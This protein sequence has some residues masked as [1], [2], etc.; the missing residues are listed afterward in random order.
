[1]DTQEDVE[2]RAMAVFFYSAR[3]GRDENEEGREKKCRNMKTSL[4]YL[5]TSAYVGARSRRTRLQLGAQ[6][7]R[8]EG[9]GGR[10]VT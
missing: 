10:K 8:V 9:G 4:H 3:S 6:C 7:E 1:V 2:A 5:T